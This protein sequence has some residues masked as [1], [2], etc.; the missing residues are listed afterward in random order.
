MNN[1]LRLL[2]MMDDELP[3]N[4]IVLPSGIYSKYNKNKDNFNIVRN[5]L[6]Y[7]TNIISLKDINVIESSLLEE[8]R[9]NVSLNIAVAMGIDVE[10]T[11]SY[12]D[13]I[14]IIEIPDN[15]PKEIC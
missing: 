2:V 5:P 1:N 9:C 6:I 15:I 8:D 3:E 7:Y 11:P 14:S 10:L 13:L 12:G 4:T